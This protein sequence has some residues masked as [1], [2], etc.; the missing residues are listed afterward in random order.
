MESQ[1]STFK[2]QNTLR[3]LGSLLIVFLLVAPFP[4]AY[5]GESPNASDIIRN[6]HVKYD[7]TTDA[8]IEFTQTIVLPLSKIS[9]TTKGTLYLKKPHMYR[10]ESGDR[11]AVTDGKTSWV[12]LSGA[13]QVI[14]DNYKEN[15]NTVDPDKF[16]MN[17]PSDYF[18]VLI[19]TNKEETDTIYT[20][21]LT[22]KSDE[23]FIRSI[24]ITV[25]N[26]WIIHSA[27]VSDMNDTRTTYTVDK[28]ET[29]SGIPDS[30][31]RFTPPKDAQV[32]D[33]RTH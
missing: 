19:S 33:L 13:R 29:D 5:P 27:E 7:T 28:I 17:V 16:L 24:R 23:S 6:L 21:R 2:I 32:V 18:A 31:F 22:P 14:I 26:D 15:K 3:A 11:I 12:Y 30:E 10:I 8:R 4:P 1:T 20:L 9:R 25:D